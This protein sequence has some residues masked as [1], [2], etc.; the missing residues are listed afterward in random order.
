MAIPLA[1]AQAQALIGAQIQALIGLIQQGV[2][3]D[4]LPNPLRQRA[5]PRIVLA[6]PGSALAVAEG[7]SL[8]PGYFELR[9]KDRGAVLRRTAAALSG[10]SPLRR[11]G[12]N[13]HHLSQVPAAAFAGGRQV[14]GAAHVYARSRPGVLAPAA[15]QRPPGAHLIGRVLAATLPPGVTV[16]EPGVCVTLPPPGNWPASQAAGRMWC[17]CHT[18]RQ[19]E[20]VLW[21]WSHFTE[22]QLLNPGIALMPV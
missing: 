21:S 13:G 4:R 11:H 16:D 5:P 17:G 8:A 9:P 18:P 10:N 22:V 6:P 19:A 14:N 20:A 3:A 12:N 7:R 15:P 2:D 1:P